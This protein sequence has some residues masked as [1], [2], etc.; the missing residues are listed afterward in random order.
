M[1]AA[2]ASSAAWF[3]I[4]FFLLVLVALIRPV[5]LY[6]AAIY[7]GRA[8]FLSKYECVIYRYCGINATQSMNSANYTKSVLAFS[9]TSIV[10]LFAILTGQSYPNVSFD[11]AFNAASSFVTNTNWQPNTPET[12]IATTSQML[13]IAVQNFLSAAVGLAVMAAFIRGLSAEKTGT[14]GNFWVDLTRGVIY[15]LLPFSALFALFYVSQG[16]VQSFGETIPFQTLSDGTTHSLM[17]GPVASQI[18]IKQLGTN[19]GGYFAANAAH[20]FEN[21]TPLSNFVQMLA[22]ILIPASAPICFGK[23][24]GQMR[25]AKTLLFTMFAIFLPLML[26]LVYTEQQGNPI[27]N[28]MGI[29]QILGNMEGK[30]VRFGATGSALW[31]SLTTA[32]ASGSTNTTLD[33]FMPLG[34]LVPL[35]LIQFGEIIF[36]GAGSGLYGILVYVMLTVFIAGLMIGRTPEYL[37]KKI[38][39]FEMK[40][41]S[42]IILI[43]V[44]TTLLCTAVSVVATAGHAQTV[45]IGAQ[46]FTELLYAFSSASNNNGSALGGMGT[47]TPYF[48]LILGFC[49][50]LGRFGIILPILAIAGSMSG[51]IAVPPSQGTLNTTSFL[52]AILLMGVI[53]L[54]GVLTYIPALTFGPMA[55]HFHLMAAR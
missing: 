25:Q 37:G 39:V 32:A 44:M 46:S 10:V 6:M 36:G 9:L 40:M 41:A 29:D 47:N 26:W 23:M 48:N 4:V 30:E 27:L 2:P 35:I 12:T 7:D 8:T 55:E 15:L 52:F 17:T 13:G 45:N 49:M 51:K 19:G 3:Q 5:G 11:L 18:A 21:P 24:T 31:A 14:I 33:S 53:V 28:T 20:P 42:L 43:P 54:V 22:I 34:S 38:G 50:L 16:I 1:I